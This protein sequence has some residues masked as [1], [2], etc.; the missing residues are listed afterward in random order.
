MSHELDTYIYARKTYNDKIIKQCFW[1]EFQWP[2]QIHLCKL[3]R[4]VDYGNICHALRL[5]KCACLIYIIS[6]VTLSTLKKQRIGYHCNLKQYNETASSCCRRG[7]NEN[8]IEIC[9]LCENFPCIFQNNDKN[10]CHGR[11][12]GIVKKSTKYIPLTSGTRSPFSIIAVSSFPRAEPD[13]TSARSRSPV[14]RCVNP[15]FLTIRSHC[16]PLPLPGPPTTNT[17][18]N[19]FSAAKE[20]YT[21]H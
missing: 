14:D 10:I 8:G 9:H 15:Y 6:T 5:N 7:W 12:Q 19:D 18:F 2:T 13:A 17:T 21:V 16:V 1:T 20:K 3:L 11:T 4:G